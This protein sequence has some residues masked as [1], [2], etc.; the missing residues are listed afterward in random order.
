M[1]SNKEAPILK[2]LF[3]SPATANVLSTKEMTITTVCKKKLEVVDH[4]IKTV[5][6]VLQKSQV[7]GKQVKKGS[8]RLA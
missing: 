5:K 2:K 4:M 6:K 8:T 1:N 7:M 3:D